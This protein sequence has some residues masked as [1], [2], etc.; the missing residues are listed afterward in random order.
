MLVPGSN[1]LNMA[2]NLI[3][4]QTFSYIAN[5]GRTTN[6]IGQ[7]IQ[8]YADPVTITG[9]LQPF[10]R[11]LFQQ[12]GL[13]FNKDYVTFFIPQSAVDVERNFSGDE[14]VFNSIK[15]QALFKTNWFQIDGWIGIVCVKV[16]LP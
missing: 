16:T 11:S 13:D 8:T 6:D 5:L 3:A 2:F 1:L 14:F 7:Y 9:S 10:P 12:Y 4:R 15:Y